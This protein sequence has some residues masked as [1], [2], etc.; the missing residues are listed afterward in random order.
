MT[1]NFALNLITI[2]DQSIRYHELR[3]WKKKNRKGGAGGKEKTQQLV[4]EPMCDFYELLVSLKGMCNERFR[5]LC[6]G[7]RG[8]PQRHAVAIGI[9]YPWQHRKEEGKQD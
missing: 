2:L 6:G 1:G 4:S 8:H 5:I 7:T 9:A 3:L